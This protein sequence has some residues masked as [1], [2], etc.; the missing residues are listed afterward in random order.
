M[1][2]VSLHLDLSGQTSAGS[3]FS[4]PDAKLVVLRWE[5][6][7]NLVS[8][9]ELIEKAHLEMVDGGAD[10]LI[11][12][13]RRLPDAEGLTNDI[14]ARLKC[15]AH[16]AVRRV[17]WLT[18]GDVVNYPRVAAALESHKVSSCTGQSFDHIAQALDAMSPESLSRCILATKAENFTGTYAGS[19]YT[20][21]K[22]N[23]TV[24]RT[25]GNA[26]DLPLS[27][28]LFHDMFALHKRSGGSAVIVDSSAT[29]TI[30]DLDRYI[31]LYQA[32]IVPLGTC[33]LFKQAIH[34]RAGDPLFAVGAPPI[35]PLITSFGVP[36][37]EVTMMDDALSLL[38]ALQGKK[39][40]AAPDSAEGQK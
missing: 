27:A 32:F 12:E 26:R 29:Q 18:V 11:Y 2:N 19:F 39:K 16:P 13:S 25:S 17:G 3:V 21:P 4:N 38:H 6:H 7:S 35:G 20:I 9:L 15:V 14:V 34:I 33:G 28:A 5:D 37:Y 8:M 31:H 1:N 30:V 24:L 23:V 40:L 36:F 10:A 22:L